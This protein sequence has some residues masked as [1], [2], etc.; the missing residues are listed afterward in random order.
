MQL[1]EDENG[2]DDRSLAITG[3]V[4][5][6]LFM[7][8]EMITSDKAAMAQHPFACDIFSYG[9]LAYQLL[10]G[11]RP[12]DNDPVCTNK[13]AHQIKQLVVMGL[14]PKLPASAPAPPSDEPGTGCEHES[15]PEGMTA[16]LQKCW[17]EKPGDRPDFRYVVQTLESMEEAFGSSKGA[18]AE[19]EAGAD[20]APPPTPIL[21]QSGFLF[22]SC[23]EIAQ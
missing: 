17:C 5:T 10:A 16:L 14:R 6:S 1:F 9:M 23:D 8:P 2:D 18:E 12:Y 13:S 20:T 4:G 19:A 15:W 3:D 7:A 21:H 11:H 22:R